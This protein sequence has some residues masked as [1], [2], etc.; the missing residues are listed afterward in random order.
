MT[1]ENFNITSYIPHLIIEYM[2]YTQSTFN[3][4]TEYIHYNLI[5]TT[6]TKQ[7]CSLYNLSLGQ[8]TPSPSL[9]HSLSPI[10][11]IPLTLYSI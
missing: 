11:I 1:S 7:E 4:T 3:I 6:T 5:N 10:E 9:T 2:V 8:I